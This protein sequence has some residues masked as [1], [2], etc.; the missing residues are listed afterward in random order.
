MSLEFIPVGEKLGDR[1]VPAP[2]KFELVINLEAARVPGLP[3]AI[4]ALADEVIEQGCFLHGPQVAR[5]GGSRQ[6]G[7]MPAMEL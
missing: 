2:T 5:S 4:I 1:P 7:K 3:L 6:R